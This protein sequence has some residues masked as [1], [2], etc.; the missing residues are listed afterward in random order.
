LTTLILL[1]RDGRV[2]QKTARGGH[3]ACSG[4]LAF[5]ASRADKRTGAPA[6]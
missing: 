3:A 6:F 5:G 2:R 1:E 4:T